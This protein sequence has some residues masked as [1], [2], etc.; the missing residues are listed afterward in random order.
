MYASKS[1]RSLWLK[2]ARIECVKF[3]VNIAIVQQIGQIKTKHDVLAA[4]TLHIIHAGG[5]RDVYMI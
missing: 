4:K 2:Y 1:V 5:A 3:R